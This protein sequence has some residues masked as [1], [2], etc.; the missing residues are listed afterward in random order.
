MNL[1]TTEN[2]RAVNECAFRNMG[3]SMLG[4]QGGSSDALSVLLVEDNEADVYLIKRA[5]AENPR[6]A[7]VVLA[8]DGVEALELIE[9]GAVDPDLAIIDLHMPRKDGFALLLDL[10][11]RAS[12]TFPSIVLTSSRSAADAFRSRSRGAELVLVKPNSAEKLN[13]LMGEVIS[14]L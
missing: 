9:S 6:V 1:S 7:E 14:I 3:V 12:T 5:L 11:L 2:L 13:A 10:R 8:Q 4:S